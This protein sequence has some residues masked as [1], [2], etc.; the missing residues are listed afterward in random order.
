[1]IGG[2]HFR[3]VS[4]DAGEQLSVIRADNLIPLLRR[5]LPAVIQKR[6]V[7]MVADARKYD[8]KPPALYLHLSFSPFRSSCPSGQSSPSSVFSPGKTYRGSPLLCFPYSTASLGQRQIQA[9]QWVQFF[10]HTGLPFS[11][12]MF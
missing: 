3:G 5:Q 11:S 9:I 6:L 7:G 8:R 10:P 4:L 12:R 2:A 1:L